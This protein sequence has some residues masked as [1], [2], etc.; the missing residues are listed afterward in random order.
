MADFHAGVRHHGTTAIVELHG[1][2]NGAADQVLNDAYAQATTSEPRAVLLD[3]SDVEYLNSTG[4]ALIVGLLAEA[5]KT[6][7]AV[8]VCGLSDHFRHI[9]E[10][11]RLADF[12]SFFPDQASAVSGDLPAPA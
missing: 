9:F 11:T 2:I 1:D 12:M 5:R 7:R 4:I 6:S 10:I 3:F 8:L